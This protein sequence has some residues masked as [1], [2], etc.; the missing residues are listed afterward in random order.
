MT[1]RNFP[2]TLVIAVLAVGTP[3]H[4]P[5]PERRDSA[6][7]K[8]V[9][10]AASAQIPAPTASET[11]AIPATDRVSRRVETPPLPALFST[12]P[13]VV[14]EQLPA[15]ESGEIETRRVVR[16]PFHFSWIRIRSLMRENRV[17]AEEAVVA[18]Q[19]LVS[20]QPG[21]SPAA[22]AAGLAAE[23]ITILEKLNGSETLVLQ[24]PD[25]DLDSVDRARARLELRGDLF[26]HVGANGIGFGAT[27]NDPAFGNQW[28]LK[29]TGQSGLSGTGIPGTDVNASGLWSI[30]GSAP[31]VL[32]AILDSGMNFSHPDLAG[33]AWTNP[34]EIAGNGI[35]DDGNGFVDDV[36]GW[37]FVN[38]DNHPADDVDHGSHVTGIIAARRDNGAGIAG[39]ADPV[40]I[41]PVK[42]LDSANT[43]TTSR[44]IAGL[45]YARLLGARV[46]NLSLQNFPNDASLAE[47]M[48]RAAAAGIVVCAAAGNQ[49]I[50][51]DNTP[52][53]PS[54]FPNA[55]IIAVGNHDRTDVR[56]AG[57]SASNYGSN[58]VDLYAPG[59]E[60][61]S[62]VLNLNYTAKTGTSMATPHV[63]AVAAIIRALNPAWTPAEVKS[64]ILATVTTRPA[65][66]GLCFSGGRL[67]AEAAIKRAIMLEPN[68]NP[69]GDSTPSL[70][71]YGVGTDPLRG[72]ANGLPAFQINGATLELS[73]SRP[74]ADIS[75]S[76]ESS[77]DLITWDAGIVNQGGT[78]SPVTATAPRGVAGQ[79]F[80]RLKVEPLP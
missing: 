1:S 35:D 48:D 13:V 39:L 14:R 31:K 8:T 20:L 5:W 26:R 55:N 6:V 29:N 65:Y 50:N 80:L 43:G 69:D 22:L 44:L 45:D 30:V 70:V 19:L 32:V 12:F 41:L 72:N 27:P 73:Y 62:T 37:D 9:A 4:L 76:V 79:R 51:N 11:L 17:V 42:I 36:N 24:L 52:N 77:D 33:V 59:T 74:R 64:C 68:A 10:S 53:Y 56:W 71:E 25:H 7:E 38:T 66:S 28:A 60:V 34:G 21:V 57:F 54:C 40:S 75:Y 23:R 15:S 58:S 61:V 49:G 3:R 78:G 18:D 67:N 2:L 63:V 47:A 46:M 16:S